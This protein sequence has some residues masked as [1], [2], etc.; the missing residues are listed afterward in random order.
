MKKIVSLFMV[1]ALAVMFGASCGKMTK[2]EEAKKQ[3][4]CK[5]DNFDKDK[6][7]K[8]N[9]KWDAAADNGK[10]KCVV[11]TTP[12]APHT[13][14][15]AETDACKNIATPSDQTACDAA[16]AN[17]TNATKAAYTC[18]FHAASGTVAA[19]CSLDKNP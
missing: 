3:D 15:Q 12:A 7:D 9:C 13:P 2:C 6:D 14:T 16:N 8:G 11:A 10:G 5:A 1:A 18:K 19:K 17:L 4:D